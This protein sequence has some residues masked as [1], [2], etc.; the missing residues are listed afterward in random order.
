MKRTLTYSEGSQP[1][2]KTG[3]VRGVRHALELRSLYIKRFCLY[4]SITLT[5]PQSKHA[6]SRVIRQV[7][8]YIQRL[9]CP[10]FH[11]HSSPTFPYLIH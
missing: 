6:G 5:Q 9:F 11:L 10:R 8:L 2:L 1:Q 4:A 7:D 3:G